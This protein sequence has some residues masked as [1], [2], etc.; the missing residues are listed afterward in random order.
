M[1]WLQRIKRKDGSVFFWVRDR[2]DGRQ[3][4]I[5]GGPSEREADLK[6]EQYEIRKD[7]EK[8]GYED[9][10]TPEQN[11]LLDCLWGPNQD[12]LKKAGHN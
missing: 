6:R 1:A 3:I 4:S 2:R 7:L 5:P 9:K 11:A 12:V 8:E 10:Y